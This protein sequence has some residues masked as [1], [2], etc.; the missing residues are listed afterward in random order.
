MSAIKIIWGLI[1]FGCFFSASAVEAAARAEVRRAD[2]ET[3]FSAELGSV[4]DMEVFIDGD[5][6]EL[7]GYSLFI[8]YDA[9]VFSL[10]P[11]EIDASG[12]EIPFH[13]GQMLGGIPL[14]NSVERVD[15]RVYMRYVEAAGG[16][17]RGGAAERG[18][19]VRFQLRVMRRTAAPTV[20]VAL[21]ERG[22][23]FRSHY[24]TIEDPGVEKPF[25]KPL[26]EAVIRVTGFRIDPLPDLT[27][28]EGETA[29]V[30]DLDAYVDSATTDVLWT[31]SRLSEIPTTIDPNTREVTMQPAAG[32][33]GQRAMIFTALEVAEGLTASDTVRIEVLSKPRIVD[34]PDTIR[35]AE[36]QLYQDLDFDAYAEDL[37]HAVADLVWETSGAS[38]LYVDVD[39]QSHIATFR[40]DPDF[41][42]Y[43]SVSFIVRDPTELADTVQTVV[44]VTPV[45]DHPEGQQLKT[46][47]PAIGGGAVS[48]PFE[49]IV[50]DRDDPIESMQVFLEVEGP[51]GAQVVDRQVLVSGFQAARGIV[52]I[53]AQDT[54]GARTSTRQVAIVLE[55]GQSVGPELA[56]LAEVRFRGGQTATVDLNGYVSD[57]SPV[58]ELGWSVQADS[59]LVAS[60]SAGV[61]QIRGQSG[62]AGSGNLA[63][64]AIDP[65]GNSDQRTVRVSI[66]RSEDDLGPRLSTAAKVGLR[67]GEN[68]QI[69]LDSWAADPDHSDET[70]SWSF[71][72]TQGVEG[73]FDVATR[74][75]NV[76]AT[77][78]FINPAELRVSVT[79]P[80]GNG[81][82]AIV[83]VLL[84]R[85]GEP[86]Q[87]AEFPAFSLERME[88]TARV[89]LDDYVYDDVDHE[90]ELVWQIE[91]EPG[92]TVQFNRITHD[93]LLRRDGT[94]QNALSATQVVVRVTDTDGLVRTGLLTVGLPPLFSLQTLPEIELIAGR[95]D[96]SIVLRDYAVGG[97]GGP[98]PELAWSVLAEGRIRAEVNSESSRLYLSL[99][100]REFTGSETLIVEATDVTG[101]KNAV[102]LKVVVNGMGL[103]PQVRPLPRIE[104]EEGQIDTSIDLDE[105]V[106]D[107]DPDDA[108]VWSAS[109][110][111]ALIVS[112]DPATHVV[113]IDASAAGPSIEKIQFVVRDPVGNTELTTVEVVVLRG[114]VAP[115][116]SELPQIL[117]TAGNPEQ[118]IDLGVFVNDADTP[119]GELVWSV[120]AQAGITARLEG[121]RLFVFVPAGQSGTRLL[122]VAV[123]DPQ[124]NVAEAEIS[125]LIE[126]DLRAPE[127]ALTV[128]RHPVFS[129]LIELVV[130][131]DES[132]VAPPSISVHGQ[133]LEVVR[134]SDST[135]VASYVHDPGEDTQYVEA[136][137]RGR[138]RG[139]NEGV[140]RQEIGLAW[141]DE[142]GANVQSPDLQ[143]M[144][145]IP[146]TA[147]QPGQMAIIYRVHPNE[148]PLGSEGQPVYS[149][150]LLGGRA[151]SAPVTVNFISGANA[152]DTLGVLEWNEGDQR[153]DALPTR[154]EG[155][156]G[157]L[158]APITRPGLY[159]VG[160]VSAD[161]I[162]AVPD[163]LVY[164]NP[165]VLT[166][167]E[168]VRVEYGLSLPGPVRIQ[169]YNVLGQSVRTVV[170]GFQEV[171]VWSVG[172]DGQ[173]HGGRRV[174]A[175]VY[176]VEL[177][178]G[179]Q[180]YHRPVIV[181]R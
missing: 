44:E 25:A 141:V 108:L 70:L 101:R 144:L 154:R 35:F 133:D 17:A 59:G 123:R 114:G 117:L 21:E 67:E 124:G 18:V 178:A 4:V 142:V 39:R 88:E 136:V 104:V 37:D 7:T 155:A 167:V 173:D 71:F 175:G 16:A 27:I 46:V 31:H 148:V 98:T 138:D 139:G 43:R 86:P 2:G 30:F 10:V 119:V 33:V 161:Q 83:P 130:I 159:R 87:L 111:K 156:T 15:G 48:I 152:D 109:G 132:L 61:L 12:T 38:E 107:D 164:P 80:Q 93:L 9:Q 97:A 149:I 78:G 57:D 92:V 63:I 90:S 52:H 129:E 121:A 29:L 79:D 5:G 163:L 134:R 106:V 81:D 24:V 145:N 19:A 151:W 137:V 115:E 96:S 28:I 100:D 125:V 122:P 91:P 72:P 82:E 170:D 49:D 102:E 13:S 22:H 128:Q 62:F 85:S 41:F 58:E 131:P 177:I 172:W 65:D 157:W 8:S 3:A 171:G 76:S 66:L 40:P 26:G 176:Y 147:A 146:S 174:A 181:L 53:T 64:A 180:R 120:E 113:T 34:F 1:L 56:E 160:R 23:D 169:I 54:S 51:I 127:F 55:E 6:Q 116:I 110:Q 126:Q 74:T 89:D 14:E 143:L 45:N 69:Q 50:F 103:S 42:G 68:V 140:R 84:A 112:I 179:G 99:S 118:Q 105:Y 165:A 77:D 95:V 166:D 11:A 20:A 75:L 73:V 162:Q 168:I 94:E 150:D 60:I 32:F 153:W 47:Y 36:D 158:A 135:Y